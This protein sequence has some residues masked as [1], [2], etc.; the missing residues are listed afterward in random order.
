MTKNQAVNFHHTSWITVETYL[1]TYPAIIELQE[2][3]SLTVISLNTRLASP[4]ALRFAYILKRVFPT[5]LSESKPAF[6]IIECIA[7][8]APTTKLRPQA[9]TTKGYVKLSGLSP[10]LCIWEKS[11]T[12]SIGTELLVYALMI[13]FQAKIGALM[14][15][16]SNTNLANS[17]E[18]DE[19]EN[20]N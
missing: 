18:T 10:T 20:M 14:G 13:E 16:L 9:L 12:A 11:F 2:T 8:P 19:M 6:T 15:N 1:A 7:P 5:Y 17:M 4:T 3:T